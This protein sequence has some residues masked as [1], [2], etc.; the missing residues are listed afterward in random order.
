MRARCWI[1]ERALV[2]LWTDAR[3][4]RLRETGGALLGWRDGADAVIAHVLGPGPDAKHGF[5]SFEPDGPWQVEQGRLIY[6]ESGRTVAYIGDWHTHPFAAPIP[7]QQD[8]R[9]AGLI[10]ADEDFRAPEPLSAIVGAPWPDRVR[11]LAP[12]LSVY[13]WAGED[14]EAMK[15]RTFRF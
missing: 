11:G 2:H 14:F 5:R 15:I 12:R 7:S 9:A 6:E 13:C 8:R 4:F 1:D 10:A 3:R